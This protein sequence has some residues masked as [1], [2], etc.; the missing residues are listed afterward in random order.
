MKS[1]AKDTAIY[2]LSSIVGRALNALL[3]PFYMYTFPN[4]GEYGKVSAIYGYTAFLGILL[5]YGMETGFFRF[6]NKE[7]EDPRKVYSSILM[8]LGTT[9][10][11]F[12][13]LCL[14]FV[15]PIASLINI[16]ENPE[17]I[18]MMA[19]V[20]AI[21][22]FMSIPFAYLRYKKRPI[23]F[24]SIKLINIFL[25][26]FFNLFF[27]L[28][29][30]KIYQSN[31]ESINWFYDPSLGIGYIFVSNLLATVLSSLLLIPEIIGFKYTYDKQLMKRI[32]T[33]SFPILILGIA[34]V[35][36]QTIA[37]LVYPFI[38][39]NPTEAFEQLGIYSACL[40]LTVIIT[41]FT[42]AF[43]YAYEPFIFAQNKDKN[44]DEANRQSYATA[45]T[46]FII[47]ALLVFLGVMFYVDLLNYIGQYK[48]YL[49]GL[50]IVPI[51]MMGEIFFGIY[52]N[53]SIWYKLTDKTKYGAWFSIIGCLITVALNFILVPLIGYIGSAWATFVCNL[54]I[55]TISYFFGQK[56]FS[57]KYDLKK[58]FSYF[59][60][61]AVVYAAAMYPDFD[62]PILKVAYRTVWLLIFGAII[63]KRDL[64]LSEIPV[65]GKRFKKKSK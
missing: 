24:A 39:E 5:I 6:M 48:K 18:I 38:F 19:I 2:G 23:R 59:L 25:S 9:S 53:L 64:P 37:Q 32:F 46:Y 51:A 27:L 7:S 45:M 50:N 55:M 42:Q 44:N 47:F 26:I 33:Y 43:R 34:G 29:C 8:S 35:I 17:Y 60:I 49:V 22:A 63:I 31:P 3:V 14:L 62:N 36:N 10:I 4:P 20:I 41:M 56:Y 12:L 11:L 65:I 16:P 40:K 58:I 57:I 54:V 1:L 52:F 61:F 15:N 30:P 28:L 21:D 13:A